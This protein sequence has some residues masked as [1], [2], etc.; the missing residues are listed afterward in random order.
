MKILQITPQAPST[1]SGGGIGVY[2]TLLSIC[3][4]PDT[5]VDYVGPKIND[6]KIIN[7]YRKCYELENENN[8]LK[9]LFIF[10]KGITNKTYFSFMKLNI[11]YN[12]YDYIVMDF[13]KLNYVLK[14]IDNSKL[15]VKVHNVEY[16]Y[17]RRQ[18]M[19]EKNLKNYIIYKFSLKQERFILNR[20]HKV[21]A[22]TNY[23]SNRITELYKIDTK[24]ILINPVC[25][26]IKKNT[27]ISH[28]KFTLLIT[29]S[30]WY[31]QNVEGIIW[32]INNVFKNIDEDI[33]L[34]I[35]GSNPKIDLIVETKKD[36][37]IELVASPSDM[38]IYF[39]VS[40]LVVAPI[41]DGAGMKVK[42]CESL[43]YGLPVVGTKH[44]FIGYDGIIDGV[45]SFVC[46]TANEFITNII[47]LY[48]NKKFLENVAD[49]ASNLFLEKYSINRSINDWKEALKENE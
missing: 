11:D 44:A 38:D 3:S 22:L 46:D 28:D 27:K 39:K 5:K 17:S 25:L 49:S 24:K 18:F 23:D 41:F 10:L 16:D 45:N 37:R 19:K 33:K 34:I 1:F 12:D 40:D 26:P 2:Q 9:R 8:I 36:S 7:M 43:S 31:M 29:G 30:L 6:L 21:L 42:V 32:F 13:T 20:S 48:K 14:K 35:A 15:V 4:I 47:K